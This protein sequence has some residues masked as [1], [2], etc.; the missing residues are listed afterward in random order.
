MD[1]TSLVFECF[2]L[3]NVLDQQREISRNLQHS[4][5]SLELSAQ[6]WAEINALI[7]DDFQKKLRLLACRLSERAASSEQLGNT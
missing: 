2:V 4:L 3:L 1:G 5:F 7:H 6:S